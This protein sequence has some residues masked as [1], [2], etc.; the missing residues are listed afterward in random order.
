MKKILML[1][2]FINSVYILVENALDFLRVMFSAVCAVVSNT[3]MFKLI[4]VMKEYSKDSE[5]MLKPSNKVF[6]MSTLAPIF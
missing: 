2:D 4:K 3:L 1:T 6:N 5:S